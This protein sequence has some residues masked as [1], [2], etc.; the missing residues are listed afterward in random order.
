MVDQKETRIL[1]IG[2]GFGGISAALRLAEKN[3]P[4]VKIT[5][6]S[7]KPHF[8][9]HPALYRVVT[10]K[11]PLEVC[12]PQNEIF[13][14]FDIEVVEDKIVK[15][16]LSK[17]KLSGVSGSKYPFDYLILA[18]GSET[19]YFD[20]PGLKEFSFGFKSITEALRLKAHLHQVFSACENA[21]KEEK[22]CLVHI[23]IVGAGASG[24]EL[25]GE[26][27]QYAKV[28]AR[29]H[30]IDPSLI[31]I[32]LVEAAARILPLLPEDVSEKVD[33]RL[34]HLGVN[35]FTN[36][37]VLAEEVEKIH[38]QDMEMKT[39]TVIWTAGVRLNNLYK[40]ISGLEFDPKGR[41]I[42]NEYLQ[43]KGYREVFIIGDAASTVYSGYAQTAIADGKIV[44]EN[45]SRLTKGQLLT[46]NTPKKPVT[47][48]PAGVGW[49]AVTIGKIKI[50]GTLGWILRRAADLRFFLSILPFEKATLAFQSGKT[51]CETC[52][53]CLPELEV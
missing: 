19:A 13:D 25:A 7:D 1:I 23:V 3:L 35:I 53:I 4:N 44:A 9:Y 50:Y 22:V 28:L 34:R 43:T 10:G 29:N 24:T 6:V 15:V 33:R 36:R 8:E 5:L 17:K 49:A 46:K 31:T 20:I 12:I 27:A 47:A 48:I 39:E 16:E 21:P 37:T 18:M 38:L 40:E 14:K 45:I 2:G 32:D 42:V 41:V 26:L 51:L 11:S 30:N 52:S